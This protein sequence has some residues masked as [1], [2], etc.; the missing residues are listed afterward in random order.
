VPSGHVGNSNLGM[1]QPLSRAGAANLRAQLDALFRDV[2][3][4]GE[5]AR[6]WFDGP[7]LAWRTT[8]PADAAL[9]VG[10][11]SLAITARLLAVMNWLLQPGH[12]G[13][14]QSLL[15]LVWDETPP[16]PDD[17]PLAGT[18]GHGIAAASRQILARAQALC[19]LHAAL[20]GE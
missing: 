11:E 20:S 2:L 16:L 9:A 10:T 3:A 7:G 19:A 14:P 8:L 1:V 17:H 12:Q 13:Q 6:G 4:A 5:A 15:P 18:P